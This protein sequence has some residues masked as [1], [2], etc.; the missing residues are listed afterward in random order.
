MEG[1]CRGV[2]G[3]EYVEYPRHSCLDLKKEMDVAAVGTHGERWLEPRSTSR[4]AFMVSKAAD[5]MVLEDLKDIRPPMYGGNPS[6]LD[7][8]L[9]KLD[10]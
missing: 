9:E 7:P 4:R 2:R 3:G 1:L 6:N 8:F 5:F 10:V